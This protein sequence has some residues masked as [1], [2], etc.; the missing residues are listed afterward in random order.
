MGN[1]SSE[2][3]A[4]MSTIKH[5]KA[6]KGDQIGRNLVLTTDGQTDRRTERQVHTLVELRF[7]AKNP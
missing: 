1:L 7:A 4:V 6:R 2:L 3:K 5:N